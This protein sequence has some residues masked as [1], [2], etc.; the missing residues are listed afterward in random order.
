MRQFVT[1]AVTGRDKTGVIVRANIEM[2]EDFTPDWTLSPAGFFRYYAF[3]NR[4]TSGHASSVVGGRKPSR[5]LK[6]C[7]LLRMQ[8]F[9]A[10]ALKVC[11]VFCFADRIRCCHAT[12]D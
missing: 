5:S 9:D 2:L 11:I 6:L 12:K 10:G 3:R 1:I 4:N 8:S 7:Q